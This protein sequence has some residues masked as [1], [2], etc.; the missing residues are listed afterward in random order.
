MMLNKNLDGALANLDDAIKL[1]PDAIMP[2][3]MRSEVHARRKEWDA[4]ETDINT[5][6][7]LRPENPL[8]QLN[9]AD[10]KLRRGQF[11][12]AR[13]SYQTMTPTSATADLISYRIFLCDLG[14]KKTKDAEQELAAFT[15]DKTPGY[16]FAH[17]A[18]ALDQGQAQQAVPFLKLALQQHP[19]QALIIY[20]AG[21]E[22][23]GYLPLLKV[24]T[25]P[26]TIGI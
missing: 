6:L 24:V 11:S 20:F 5:A 2:Y 9:A 26:N 17:A 13:A 19:R 25:D 16:N 14:L 22:W 1:D 7:R 4:A 23:L 21:L 15:D 10:L 8:V 3:V 12:E 18:W